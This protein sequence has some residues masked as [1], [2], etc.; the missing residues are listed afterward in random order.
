MKK[1]LSAF[2]LAFILLMGVCSAGSEAAGTVYFTAVNDKLLDLSDSTMPFWSGGALYVPTGVYAGLGLSS[3]YNASA[4]TLTLS[5]GS[6][7]LI[8]NLSADM[9]VDSRGN[10]YSDTPVE[11]YGQVFLPATL[12]CRVFSYTVTTRAVTNGYLVRIKNASAYYSDEA[13]AE[14]VSA[15]MNARYEEYAAAHS[16]TVPPPEENDG[17]ETGK[18]AFFAVTVRSGEEAERVLRVTDGGTNRVTFL[19]TEEFFRD[20]NASEFLRRIWASGHGLGLCADDLAAA[21]TENEKLC[22]A[23]C[24]KTRLL[25]GSGLTAAQAQRN[26]YTILASDT[27]TDDL[28]FT[29]SGAAQR[30]LGRMKNN[31]RVILGTVPPETVLRGFFR[32]AGTGGYTFSAFREV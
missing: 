5:S 15:T 14:S 12:V 26:G 24:T 10:A 20:E 2:L 29:A 4:K 17:A 9:I 18:Q 30:L 28:D 6:V 19:L 16:G 21:E 1:R 25:C 3:S 22:A 27:A 32:N 8:C 7:R 13:F 11:R 23:T 31:S